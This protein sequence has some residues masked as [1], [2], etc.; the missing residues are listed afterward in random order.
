LRAIVTP[1]CRRCTPIRDSSA[2]F[3]SSP[4][5]YQNEKSGAA[6]GKPEL[7]AVLLV[8]TRRREDPQFTSHA[9]P[10]GPQPASGAPAHRPLFEGGMHRRSASH[11]IRRTR[12]PCMFGE[13][14]DE[15]SILGD[16]RLPEATI[17]DDFR[18]RSFSL[19]NALPLRDWWN[20]S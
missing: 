2:P 13:C 1:L 20:R 16:A 15:W 3:G 12:H 6:R 10:Y 19:R 14:I 5:P 9:P 7:G 17:F 11:A 18:H 4:V 8:A